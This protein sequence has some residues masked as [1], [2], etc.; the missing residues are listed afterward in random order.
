MKKIIIFLLL[1]TTVFAQDESSS[2][3]S[4]YGGITSGGFEDADGRSTGLSLGVGYQL[5]DNLSIGGGLSHRGGKFDDEVS[6]VDG[7]VKYEIKGNALELWSSYSLMQSE[8]FSLS[9]GLIYA[10]IYEFEVELFGS[11]VTV[12]ESEDDYGFYVGGSIPLKNNLGLNIGYYHGLKD[13]EDTPKFNNV[14]FELGYS[15]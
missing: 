1:I 13:N 15:F 10:H 12:D 14:W 6:G 11:S 4:I 2:P 7:N 9:T 8:R 5:N 3:W